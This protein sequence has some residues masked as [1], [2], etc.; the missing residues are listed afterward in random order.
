MESALAA[1]CLVVGALMV[2]WWGISIGTGALTRPDRSRAEI[3]LHL[4]AELVTAALLIAGGVTLLAH[5][6]VVVAATALGMLLYTVIASPGYF[7]ARREW[8]PP[9][10]FGFLTVLT[11]TALF[12]VWSLT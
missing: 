4:T 12:G 7:L 10:M 11:L 3:G 1:Y 2:A 8:A 9:I 5:G 6:T